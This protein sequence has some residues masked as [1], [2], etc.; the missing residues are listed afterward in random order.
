MELPVFSFP[1]KDGRAYYIDPD[2]NLR[3]CPNCKEAVEM[4]LQFNGQN[5][6][7]PRMCKCDQ[8]ADA[9][10]QELERMK[11]VD[12]LRAKCLPAKAR[13]HRFSVAEKNPALEKG[14]AYIENW[15]ALRAAGRG[16]LIYGPV[17]T[18]K[19][20]LADCIANALIEQEKPVLRVKSTD[21]SYHLD[22]R[23]YDFLENIKRTPLLIIDDLG[24]ERQT[25]FASE[26]VFQVIDCRYESG[27]PMIVTTNFTRKDME[28]PPVSNESRDFYLRAF[29][30]LREACELLLVNGSDR[31][32]IQ[33]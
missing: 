18:G 26:K 28:N 33:R 2:D 23:N 5:N 32:S 27:G 8:E 19:S 9:E 14:R 3:H 17:G 25:S 22:G 15:N 21:I 29:S 13:A 20:F 10:K 30:R 31:R 7:V 6:I 16:L 1:L 24:A 4:V 11:R 12:E